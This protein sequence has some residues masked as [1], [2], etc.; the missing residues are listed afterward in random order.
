MEVIMEEY[1]VTT[2]APLGTSFDLWDDVVC[3]AIE[4]FYAS[5]GIV[6]R[7]VPATSEFIFPFDK[8]DIF[9]SLSFEDLREFV[10]SAYDRM[11]AW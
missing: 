4:S 11:Y 10:A 2:A 5:W 3:Q 9:Y 1:V 7:V 8:S 6:G